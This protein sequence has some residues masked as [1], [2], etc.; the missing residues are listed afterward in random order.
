[1]YFWSIPSAEGHNEDALHRKPLIPQGTKMASTSTASAAAASSSYTPALVTVLADASFL[2][3]IVDVA[4]F[5]SRSKPEEKRP[6]YVE[7]W[8]AKASGDAA[9]AVTEALFAEFKSLGDG[10]D[11]EIEGAHN[12]MSALILNLGDQDKAQTLTAKHAQL[13]ATDFGRDVVKYRM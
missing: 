3:Q 12:L 13:V 2:D 6:Q 7:S 11:R 5:L 9:D 8:S 4:T 1:M 10:L